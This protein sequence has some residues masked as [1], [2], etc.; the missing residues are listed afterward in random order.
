M[1]QFE[2]TSTVAADDTCDMRIAR[3]R[4][5]DMGATRGG[6]RGSR[7]P[8]LKNLKILSKL[9]TEKIGVKYV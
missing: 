8:N 2:V 1:S 5:P 4:L 6:T 7:T 9:E 3:F